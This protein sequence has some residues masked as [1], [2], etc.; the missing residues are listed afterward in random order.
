MVKI[1]VT[2]L[3]VSFVSSLEELYSICICLLYYSFTYCAVVSGVVSVQF[4]GAA[5]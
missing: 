3:V 2:K 5:G 4:M 1:Y